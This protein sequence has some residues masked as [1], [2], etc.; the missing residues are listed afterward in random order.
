MMLPVEELEGTSLEKSK[1]NL[2][3]RSMLARGGWTMVALVGKM[4]RMVMSRLRS[5]LTTKMVALVDGVVMGAMRA[6]ATFPCLSDMHLS[7]GSTSPMA[8]GRARARARAKA[9]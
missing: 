8:K 9:K 4:Y 5:V 2:G 6:L 7:L 3:S 1:V